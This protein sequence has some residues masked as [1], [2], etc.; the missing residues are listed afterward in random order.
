[1]VNKERYKIKLLK[2]LGDPE[3]DFPRRIDYPNII[4]ISK[5]TLYKHFTPLE[6]SEIENEAVEIRKKSCARQ[7]SEVLK[8]LHKRAI[9]FSHHET[10]F[11]CYEGDII[12]E[13][14]EKIYPPDRAAAQEFLDRT[15]GKVLEKKE[16]KVDGKDLAP[17]LNVT[18]SKK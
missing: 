13:E 18:L 1:M 5:K 8:A 17:I 2:S 6:L 7:R 16:V 9:G 12:K 14:T 3:K 4:D 11:F 15:E 10:K